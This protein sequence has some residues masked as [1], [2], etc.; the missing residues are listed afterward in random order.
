M[1]NDTQKERYKLQATYLNNIAVGVIL[2]GVVPL[3]IRMVSGEGASAG[4]VLP[5]AFLC[6]ASSIFL[7]FVANWS[8]GRLER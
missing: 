8:L 1:A 2:I 3:L 7:H 5:P 6:V 4:R